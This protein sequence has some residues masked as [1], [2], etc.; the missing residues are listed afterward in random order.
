M[1]F[2]QFHLFHNYSVLQNMTLAP[3]FVGQRPTRDSVADGANLLHLFGLSHLINRMP[4]RLSGGE[5]QRIGILRA[6]ATYPKTLLF[7]EPTSALDPER[8]GERS[9]ERRVGNECRRGCGR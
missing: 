4:Q 9:E 2:Q 1:V 7:D 8:V 5:Q 3:H 6:L